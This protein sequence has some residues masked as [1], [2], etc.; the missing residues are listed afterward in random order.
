VRLALL[1][2]GTSLPLIIFAAGIVFNNYE[3]DRRD[4][5]QRVL[6]TVRSIRLVL[7]AEMQRMTGGLQ[8]LAL[9][10]SLRSGDFNNFRRIALG[11]LDQY[12]KD[13]VVLVADREG[14]QL[15]SSVT[16]DI[17]TLPP[18]NNRDIVEKVF[19][20]RRPYYSNLFTGA[21]K[22]RLIVTVEVP[23][24]RD[25]VVLYDISF[26]PPIEIFQAIVEQQRP[27]Q[28]WTISIFDGEGTN[29]A[30]VPNPQA[31]I[32]RRA[33]PSLY[34]Q[35]FRTPEATFATVS[36]EGLPLITSIARSS[37]TGWTVAAG[38]AETSLVAPL[39]RSLAITS[40]IG[41]MLLLVGLA[42]A[43]R[44]ATAIARGEML[45]GLLIEELNHRVKNTL[46]I[47]QSIATQTFR[48]ASRAEREKF[49]GRL[50]A[51]AEAHNLLSQE[52]WQGSE[53]QDVIARVLNPYLL[54]NPD[55]VRMFGPKV[56]LSPRLAVVLS[57]ILHEIATNAAK[58]GA[59][60]NDT[61]TVTLDWEILE[62]SDGRKLRLIW[63]EAGGP[64]VTAPV[65]RGF[66]SRLIERSARDQLGGE[67]TV[68]F[69]PR[70]VVCTV[71]SALDKE[72]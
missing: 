51:L 45:H 42:F 24:I 67:A 25:G 17:A 65:Q 14:R 70:G 13:G 56:P 28:D 72:N 37:L 10:N 50:G 53:L 71:T 63:T 30:R 16:P 27:A 6:E 66:G 29:F 68:D 22:K 8:V 69:L 18:R 9:T 44:M 23:V 20:T 36:L 40:V 34:A 47:L 12:G 32:G 2:A 39:W 62:E 64:H 5:T 19:A 54:N 38:I 43:V 11:F 41:G 60:S 58:Y 1:V 55:R 49:E 46:A 31:T 61:G 57:M 21:V 15:F 48:S 59:L 26:S 4:A 35:M 3:Q 52:K 33:S 7:D